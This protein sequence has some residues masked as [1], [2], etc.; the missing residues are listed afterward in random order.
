MQNRTILHKIKKGEADQIEKEKK[1]PLLLF[2]I[3]NL[4]INEMKN[5]ALPDINPALFYP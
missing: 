3:A 2:F 1:L 5:N 4:V